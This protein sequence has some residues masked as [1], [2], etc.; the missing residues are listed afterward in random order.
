MDG[1]IRDHFDASNEMVA[2][3]LQV[4][5]LPGVRTKQGDSFEG[6]PPYIV[7]AVNGTKVLADLV[8]VEIEGYTPKAG[9]LVRLIKGNEEDGDNR[10]EIVED[11]SS[12]EAEAPA[13]DADTSDEAKEGENS[14]G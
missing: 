3:I 14:D 7:Y 4:R 11:V 9:D 2:T 13:E 6:K 5:I 10:P 8:D 12:V 1:F